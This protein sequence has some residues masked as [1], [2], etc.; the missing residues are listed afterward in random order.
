MLGNM[1]E[2]GL[3]V[4]KDGQKALGM[5]RLAYKNGIHGE[6]ACSQG[7]LYYY[8]ELVEEDDRKA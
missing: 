6:G 7:K 8:G 3:G 4:P 5:Y 1:Y 2:E